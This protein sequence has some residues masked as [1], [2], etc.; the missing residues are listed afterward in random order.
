M[1]FTIKYKSNFTNDLQLMHE[2]SILIIF[3]IKIKFAKTIK[4]YF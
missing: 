4:K 3:C 1:M 2:I